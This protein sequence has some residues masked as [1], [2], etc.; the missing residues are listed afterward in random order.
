MRGLWRTIAALLL[1][2]T[3]PAGHAAAQTG[4]NGV[5]TFKTTS[6]SGRIDTVKQMTKGRRV[7]LDGF[8]GQG[9]AMI[10]DND[11]KRI[12][13]IQPERK[14]YMTMTEDDAKQMQAMMGPMMD[15]MKRQQANQAGDRTL[16]FTKTGKTEVVAGVRCEV[17]RGEVVGADQDKDEGEACVAPGVGFALAD[18]T[19][20][21]PMLMGRGGAND[22][23]EQYRQLVG[24]NKGILKAARIENGKAVNDLEAIKIEK[25]DVPDAMFAPPA[26]Y[27]EIRMAE[28]MMKA[29]GAMRRGDSSPAP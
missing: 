7:R 24:T 4:F 13:L 27:T 3:L 9:G 18:L 12:M 17:Y 21:N 22:R 1:A 8:G 10:I 20:N 28:M 14:Q 16:N 25:T 15:K 6:S 26:G 2:G 29:R 19:F 11:A 5:I 23:F